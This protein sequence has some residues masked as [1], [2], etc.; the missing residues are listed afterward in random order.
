M[1]KN[2]KKYIVNWNSKWSS[3]HSLLNSTQSIIII[4]A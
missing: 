1:E 3:N 2:G 4:I